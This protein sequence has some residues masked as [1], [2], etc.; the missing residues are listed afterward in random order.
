NEI[1]NAVAKSHN[2]LTIN[3]VGDMMFA[4]NIGNKVSSEGPTAVFKD[5]KPVLSAADL[6]L[7]NLESPLFMR[8][9]VAFLEQ[10]NPNLHLISSK[11]TDKESTE[12]SSET[13]KTEEKKYEPIILAGNPKAID[14]IADS[15]IDGVTLANNHALDMG[16]EG[17]I[18]TL[19]LLD[20]NNIL[21][22]GAGLSNEEALKPAIFE[23][24][25][26]R[27]AYLG[28]SNIIPAG[29]LAGPSKP[30]IAGNRTQEDTVL[31]T[32]KKLDEEYDLVIVS[33]HWGTEYSDT[34]ME[35][36]VAFAHKAIEAGADALINAHPHVLQ[37]VE[38]FK[39]KPILYSMG[40]FIFDIYHSHADES[41]IAHLEMDN[42]A[43]L[44]ELSFTP[45]RI[46]GGYPYLS[47]GEDGKK[48][49]ERY[50]KLSKDFDTNIEI[51]DGKGYVLL[52]D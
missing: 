26:I 25:G 44:L 30:G 36:D 51:R 32:I 46:K 29:Y 21:H 49:L 43:N 52:E 1:E 33:I 23:I 3:A 9:E 41:L 24:N 8:N 7:A 14:G 19:K 50:A 15:G 22:T 17:L 38:I 10:K 27:V 6:T 18:Q 31:S 11:D 28:T 48:I 2:S 40:D 20:N 47:T 42:K 34:P 16:Q 39:G 35:K 45:V 5:V 4:R 12:T 37:G 13:S